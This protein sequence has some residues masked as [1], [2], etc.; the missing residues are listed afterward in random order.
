MRVDAHQAAAAALAGMLTVTGVAHF[1][2][3]RFY[4][5][6]IPHA[7]PGTARGWVLAS[8][9]AELAVA[10]AVFARRSRR[11]GATMAAVLF[12]AVFPANVQMAVNWSRRSTLEST[13]AWARLPIQV[14]LV[15]WALRVRRASAALTV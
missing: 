2:V 3:P 12:I 4:D 7:L 9:G 1:V 8:G 5:P 14:P 10:A 6:I 15:W 13:L 11:A